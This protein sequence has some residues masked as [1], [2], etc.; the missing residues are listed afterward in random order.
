MIAT[1]ATLAFFNLKLSSDGSMVTVAISVW[2]TWLRGLSLSSSTGNILAWTLLLL[3]STG[4]SMLI[5]HKKYRSVLHIVMISAL[6]LMIALSQ[7][8]LVN[9][10]LI[11][12]NIQD[13]PFETIP[14]LIQIFLMVIL[15]L[16]LIMILYPLIGVRDDES[17]LIMR[18]Q[19]F[20]FIGLI[21]YASVI[22][23]SVVSQWQS[24]LESSND[25]MKAFLFLIELLPSMLLW[26]VG[27][28]I[29]RFL[30]TIKAGLF[31]A[32]NLEA[33]R[34]LKRLA[35]LS[36]N[37]SVFSLFAFNLLQLVALSL[38]GEMHFRVHIPMAELVT[39]LVVLFISMILEK[40]IPVHQ[41]NQTFV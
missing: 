36:L 41:E 38:S 24:F 35:Y 20:L 9:P 29:I 2:I 11:F 18:F 31:E 37:V 4:P 40:S 19:W 22:S 7:Y 13:F 39:L 21:A 33:L 32:S 1:V 8:F 26:I 3:T 12:T 15:S 5:F 17:S 34:K 23:I 10:W 28:G 14:I 25:S 27:A 16:G 30:Q 6:C